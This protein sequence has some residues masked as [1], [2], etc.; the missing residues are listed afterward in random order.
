M[1]RR[2]T[3][4]T[5]CIGFGALLG[6]CSGSCSIEQPPVHCTAQRA[7]FE[8]QV[9]ARFGD[10]RVRRI[11]R[12]STGR[13]GLRGRSGGIRRRPRLDG[14][15]VARGR[16]CLQ[17]RRR[18]GI[19]DPNASHQPYAIGKFTAFDPGP[20]GVCAV[21]VLAP[22]SSICRNW[23]YSPPRRRR[24]LPRVTGEPPTTAGWRTRPKGT[25]GRWGCTRAAQKV[26]RMLAPNQ[27][28]GKAR[29]SPH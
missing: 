21:P 22:G 1:E 29:H 20:D 13:P 11:E 17:Q 24:S 6:F 23:T 8:A 18:R 12:R 19:S 3:I 15:R 7:T 4:V 27:Q 10:G 14:H 2:R 9:H 26:A 16:D 25:P 28:R 5:A